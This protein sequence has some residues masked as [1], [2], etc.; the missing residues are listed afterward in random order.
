MRCRRNTAQGG[1]SRRTDARTNLEAHS[2]KVFLL[3]G[4]NGE[5]TTAMTF[6]LPAEMDG[7]SKMEIRLAKKKK[8]HKSV[9]VCS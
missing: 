9:C 4:E 7:R 8:E 5:L 1:S 2:N 3:L 6:F